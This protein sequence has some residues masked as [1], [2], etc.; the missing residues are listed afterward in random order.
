MIAYAISD[1]TTLNFDRLSDDLKRF[2]KKAD[3]I[4]YRDKD[5]NNYSD[6]AK[7]FIIEA[8]KYKFDK[9]IIHQDIDLAC[10][11]KADG[12]H[13]TSAQF[14]NIEKAAFFGLFT[15]VST[16]TLSEV[17]EAQRLGANM[18]TFSP[19]FETPNK[20]EPKGVFALKEIVLRTT[21]PVIAL[22]GIV[23]KKQ[24]KACEESGAKGFASIRY[25]A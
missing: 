25:F 16:H 18:I 23:D 4:V 8:R 3:M 9:I 24:I 1:P 11:L 22:G 15:I 12:V 20:G 19:I 2:S 6:N 7:K 13:L 14:N 21:I 5:T 10:L 17:K